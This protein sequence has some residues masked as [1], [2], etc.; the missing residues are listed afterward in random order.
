MSLIVTVRSG[1]TNTDFENE[2]DL[3]QTFPKNYKTEPNG[4]Y[5]LLFKPEL[6]HISRIFAGPEYN[7]NDLKQMFYY[8]EI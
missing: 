2:Q 1:V 3:N 7:L 4:P 6:N 5:T 8:L